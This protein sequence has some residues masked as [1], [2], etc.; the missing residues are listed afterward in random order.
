MAAKTK[1]LLIKR[2]ALR[3]DGKRYGPGLPDGDIVKNIP[4]AEADL[5]IEE[6]NG[7][8]VEIALEAAEPV[9]KGKNAEKKSDEETAGLGGIDPES[10]VKK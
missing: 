5:I 1:T 9:G 4:V 6:S 7:T 10:T 2:F 3:R 8:I